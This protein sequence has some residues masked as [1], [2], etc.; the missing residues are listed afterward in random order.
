LVD[1]LDKDILEVID[2][3]ASPEKVEGFERGPALAPIS[4]T[5]LKQRL[6]HNVSID[7]IE[8]RLRRL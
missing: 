7:I 2:R 8:S 4:V 1:L 5:E 3:Y 6:K